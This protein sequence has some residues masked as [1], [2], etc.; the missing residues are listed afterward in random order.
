MRSTAVAVRQSACTPIEGTFFIA[1]FLVDSRGTTRD[2]LILK[3]KE[4]G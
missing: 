4:I 2:N 1:A 3:I